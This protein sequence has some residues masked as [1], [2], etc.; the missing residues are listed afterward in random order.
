MILFSFELR[1]FAFLKTMVL[2][3]CKDVQSGPNL[4]TF[5][6]ARCF[7][8]FLEW[9][10]FQLH[11]IVKIC[12]SFNFSITIVSEWDLCFNQPLD[13]HMV[14]LTLAAV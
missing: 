9:G 3:P 2:L 12:L 13:V 7:A 8:I 1:N 10:T 5:P 4:T 6:C 14:M 11:C